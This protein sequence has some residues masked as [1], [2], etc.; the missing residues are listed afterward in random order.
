MRL[1]QF[2][3]ALILGIFSGNASALSLPQCVE[4]R[5]FPLHLNNCQASV[6]IYIKISVMVIEKDGESTKEVEST[7]GGSGVI[8]SEDGYILTSA[9]VISKSLP[10]IILVRYE[11][12]EG[13]DQ[14]VTAEI[15]QI[16]HTT[17][18]DLALLKVSKHFFATVRLGREDELRYGDPVYII[19]TPFGVLHHSFI[20]SYISNWDARDNTIMLGSGVSPGSSGGGVYNQ[21]G[22]LIGL[23]V[24]SNPI[25]SYA[26][27]I[28]TI[29]SFLSKSP[30]RDR[31]K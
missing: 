15:V 21:L 18:V 1:S 23:M 24:S 6:T 8:F 9:H 14:A 5:D 20:K 31:L 19:G 2:V 26:I 30:F 4:A 16:D 28:R 13:E 17:G 27:P 10:K 22:V 12:R 11:N 25:S 29:R 3:L 7:L